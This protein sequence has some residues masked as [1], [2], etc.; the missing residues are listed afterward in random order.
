MNRRRNIL[1]TNPAL[2]GRAAMR[3]HVV[4]IPGADERVGWVSLVGP[5]VH[6]HAEDGEGWVSRHASEVDCIRWLE[7]TVEADSE[8]PKEIFAARREDWAFMDRVAEIVAEHAD[9]I[10]ALDAADRAVGGERG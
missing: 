7:D 6:F 4:F 3:A 10:A 8:V 5:W 9:V 1:D 2:D